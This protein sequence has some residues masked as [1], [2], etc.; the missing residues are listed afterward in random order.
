MKLRRLLR[1][2]IVNP[3]LSPALVVVAVIAVAGLS[4]CSSKPPP[5]AL[6]AVRTAEVR[7]DRAQ[8]TDRYVGTVQARHEVN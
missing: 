4:A 8:E 6:R 1:G 5:E 3:S 7:Y 2:T